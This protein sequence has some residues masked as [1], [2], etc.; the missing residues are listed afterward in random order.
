MWALERLMRPNLHGLQSAEDWSSIKMAQEIHLVWTRFRVL[1]LR[2]DISRYNKIQMTGFIWCS[3]MYWGVYICCT[4]RMSV[5][6]AYLPYLLN[7]CLRER[8]ECQLHFH[9]PSGALNQPKLTLLLVD[10]GG[11]LGHASESLTWGLW[12]NKKFSAGLYDWRRSQFKSD[13]EH[14]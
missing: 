3:S 5:I 1:R 4:F 6:D 8:F 2:Q 9:T 7:Y 10:L 13:S 14:Q 12:A 11:W